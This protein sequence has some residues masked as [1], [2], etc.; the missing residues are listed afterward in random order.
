MMLKVCSCI[1][2]IG[3]FKGSKILLLSFSFLFCYNAGL[4]AQQALEFNS[5]SYSGAV[6]NGPATT[7]QSA[8]FRENTS[9]ASFAAMTN[10]VT[11]TAA[12]SNQQFT[13][14]T[15]A[16][17]GMLFGATRNGAINFNV[18]AAP[19]LDLLNVKG[20]PSSTS[21]TSSPYGAAGTGIDV[22]VNYAFE[23]FTVTTM[24]RGTSGPAGQRAYYGDLTFSFS[25]P[26]ADPV[27]HI[28]EIGGNTGSDGFATEFEL[29]A[30]SPYTFTKLSGT[31]ELNV[32][33]AGDKILNSAADPSGGCGSGAACGSVRINGTN[34]TAVTMRVYVRFETTNFPNSINTAQGDAFTISV[35]AASFNLTGNVYNDAN[36]LTDNT[37]NGILTNTGGGLNG[38][39]VDQNGNVQGS[40]SVTAGGAISFRE[41]F[42]G[43]YTVR[44]STTAGIP[45]ST[46]PSSSLP[47][48]WVNTGEFLGTGAGSD[49]A[50]DGNLNASINIS[51]TTNANFGINRIPV[52]ATITYNILTMPAVNSS[53]TLSG[54]IGSPTT[55]NS[56][57]RPN[58]NDAEDGALGSGN[59]FTLQTLAN[60][61]VLKYNNIPLTIGQTITNFNPALLT[62][63]FTP[64][65]YSQVLFNYSYSD[66]AGA[67]SAPALYTINLP[68]AIT[69]PVTVT[70]FSATPGQNN[71]VLLKWQTK[72]EQ[73]NLGFYIE[74]AADGI[75]WQSLGFVNGAGN[76]N[77][78]VSYN[79]I[80]N[81]TGKGLHYYRL[82]QVDIDQHAR[83][84]E[85]I[86]V[87]TSQGERE[88]QV[89]P[90]PVRNT[91]YLLVPGAST[92]KFSDIS[93][94]DMNGRVVLSQKEQFSGMPVNLTGIPAG[95][96]FIRVQLQDEGYKYSKI[97]KQ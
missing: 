73:N 57:I 97:I 44:L 41:L 79:Y 3:K 82:K 77:S 84:S 31:S 39:V 74:H 85:I 22:D 55:G 62:L 49:G 92:E 56:P 70:D 72:T 35:S 24:W 67:I 83:F 17:A 93:I 11:V 13:G 69:L 43:S 14:I 34:I 96:Y 28:G 75:T 46:P 89:Y 53:V 51:N 91:C 94:F 23:L 36:G 26:V 60:F 32:P 1:S 63:Q 47:S 95:T 48:G 54:A 87:S 20:S 19:V 81:N 29:P 80:H 9:G 27:L 66:A 42:R 8:A 21:Y 52:A 38:V 33:V 4:L 15:G 30:G 59:T 12:F 65:T 25:R 71:N 50:V 68:A 2:V 86:L 5:A 6:P 7:S 18:L 88:M 45:G 78:T 37:V 16:A 64:G 90:N 10:P 61:G 40:S 76:S 58:G